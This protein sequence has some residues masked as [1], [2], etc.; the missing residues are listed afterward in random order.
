MHSNCTINS[1]LIWFPRSVL[2][3]SW[4]D[5]AR[6]NGIF[7]TIF[8]SPLN[9]E[10]SLGYQLFINLSSACWVSRRTKL[11]KCSTSIGHLVLQTLKHRQL[12]WHQKSKLFHRLTLYLTDQLVRVDSVVPIEIILLALPDEWC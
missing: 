5:S 4:K 10:M 2:T 12:L 11:R 8:S 9:I 7:S 6:S 3:H 1:N